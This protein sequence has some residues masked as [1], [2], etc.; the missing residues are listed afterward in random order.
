M[1]SIQTGKEEEEQARKAE[2]VQRGPHR[3][4]QGGCKIFHQLSRLGSDP[5][6]QMVLRLGLFPSLPGV[7][8]LVPGCASVGGV[9]GKG[10]PGIGV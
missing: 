5:A 3:A 6:E 7:N 4:E 10:A 8:P 2:R 1:A 9:P